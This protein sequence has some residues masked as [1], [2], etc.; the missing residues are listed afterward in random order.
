M[1]LR[2]KEGPV[3]QFHT[4]VRQFHTKRAGGAKR[5][6]I[7]SLWYEIVSLAISAKKLWQGLLMQKSVTQNYRFEKHPLFTIGA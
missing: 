4:K 7:V 3:R 1:Q 6:E 2:V 5:Y